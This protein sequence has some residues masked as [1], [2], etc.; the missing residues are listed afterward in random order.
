MADPH[1]DRVHETKPRWPKRQ[2]HAVTR[3]AAPLA[4]DDQTLYKKPVR[5]V[6]CAVID[7]ATYGHCKSLAD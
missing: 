3:I 4:V 5:C 2:K 1:D 6:A 7:M